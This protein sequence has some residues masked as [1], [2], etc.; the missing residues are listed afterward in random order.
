MIFLDTSAIYAMADQADPQHERA[1][2][3]FEALLD[4]GERILTHNYV[5]VETMALIQSR[6]GMTAALKLAHDCRVF[7]IDWIDEATHG[8]AVRCLTESAKRRVSLVDQVSFLV[9]R[10]RGVRTALAFDQDF[11]REG[12]QVFPGGKYTERG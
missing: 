8:E 9:M 12:F 5:L 6:L 4:M 11:E 2:E 3:R 1:K 7:D 10:R